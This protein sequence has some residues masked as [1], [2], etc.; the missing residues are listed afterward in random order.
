MSFA[1][2]L[3]YLRKRDKV[4]QEELADR[5]GVSRQSVS[6]WE[7]GE[8]YPETEK[9]LALC[10]LFE[11]SLDGLMR[12][13]LTAENDARDTEGEPQR[14]DD[15]PAA[16]T[17]ASRAE[18]TAHVNAFARAMALGVALIL[19]GV[20]A[21]V[22]LAGYSLNLE[23]PLYNFVSVMSGVAVILF[24]AVAVFLFVFYGMRHDRFKKE[25][26][27]AEDVD[28][29]EKKDFFKRFSTAM[30]CL[31]SG[32]LLDVIVLIVFA[33]LLESD[34]IVV[35]SDLR[36]SVASYITA[37]FFVVLSFLVGGLVYF[38]IQSSKYDLKEYRRQRE[39]EGDPMPLKKLSDAICGV[40]MMSATALYLVLGFVWDLWHPGWLVFP[41][42]GI[43][44]GIISAIANIKG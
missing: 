5:L 20:A 1:K 21:C 12:G 23:K 24:V 22:A 41:I 26:V 27:I 9:L 25:H 10:D 2:N 16:E 34:V 3:Q 33:S 15:A 11:V 31:I 43:L 4:T 8:A 17:V 44:C 6:K 42:G 35:S 18:L 19:L 39:E 38:G 14:A 40:V 29:R 13:D 30:A 28:E 32:I 37:G 7:T 36:A